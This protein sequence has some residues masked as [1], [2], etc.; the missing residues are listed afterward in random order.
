MKRQKVILVIRDGWG[1][2]PDKR[3][4]AIYSAKT[5]NT[6]ELMKKYPNTLINASGKAVGLPQD[7]QGNSEVGHLTIGAGRIIEQ[8]LK[9]INDSINNGTFFKIPEFLKAIEKCKKNGTGLHIAGLLQ[10][11]G[12]H[13]HKEH[14]FALLEL[15]RKL[16]FYN[17]FLHLF[18]D[19]RDAP[20][21]AS[22]KHIRDVEKKL[23]RLGF[24]RIATISGRYYAMDRDKRW[25]RTKKA[26]ECIVEGR[27]KTFTNSIEAVNESHE[28]GVTDEFLRPMKKKGY[29]GIKENDSFIFYNFRTD[30]PR[31][32]TKAIVEPGFKGF[33]RKRKG[34]NFVAMTQYYK[35]MKADVAF[36]EERLNN[37]LGEVVSANRFR[38]LRISETEKY[39]HVTFFFNGQ[40]EKKS[41]GETRVLINSPKVATYDLLPEMSVYEIT[42]SLVKEIAKDK[43]ELIVVNLVNA[44]M[45]GHT[46]DKKAIKKA[47]E[48]VDDC[49]GEIVEAGLKKDYSLLVF[50]DHGNAED[51]RPKWRTSHTI[52]PVPL[53][54]VSNKS[55]VRLKKNKGLKDIAP[56][57]LSLLGIKRPPEMSGESIILKKK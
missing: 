46:G 41:R 47:L 56:T 40:N 9:R 31:Q 10:E 25:Q 43:Y 20:V 16:E 33:E 45:V 34:V 17:V 13:S 32:L 1:Y 38:Q 6:D 53:I 51:Q 8:S 22:K 7:Y 28:S 57:A 36:K 35:N 15:C 24:G 39:A 26:Y 37:L 23:R 3:D 54:F 11:E 55:G 19:G 49:L 29:A 42:G 48:A 27:G 18:T 2:R 4:N 14:L 21:Y 44:D 5:P 30:R 52:N 50:G 12:V